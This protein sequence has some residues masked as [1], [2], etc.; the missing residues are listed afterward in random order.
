MAITKSYTSETLLMKL[1]RLG[2][3]DDLSSSLFMINFWILVELPIAIS[4][5]LSKSLLFRRADL[6]LPLLIKN[7]LDLDPLLDLNLIVWGIY[8]ISLVLLGGC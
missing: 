1:M 5:S 4:F 7:P 2:F 3:K 6:P 8:L